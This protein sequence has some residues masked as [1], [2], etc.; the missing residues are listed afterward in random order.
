MKPSMR[1]LLDNFEDEVASL[2]MMAITVILILQICTRYF[3]RDPL[4]WTEEVSRHLFVWLVFFGASGAIRDRSHVAVDLVNASLPPRI[5]LIVMLGSNIFVLFFLG[6]VLYW[7]SKAVNRMWSLSTTTL[8]IPF[9]LVYMVFPV[10]ASLMIVRT[11]A[12]MREDLMAGG[13]IER[14]ST[15]GMG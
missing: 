2:L 7:G 11:F 5:R 1:Y 9:G 14:S 6:N 4:S 8:E 12:Q 13:N 10:T 15:G 3:L